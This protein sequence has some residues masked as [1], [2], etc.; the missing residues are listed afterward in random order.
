MLYG[1]E[2]VLNLRGAVAVVT[3]GS[4]GI[5]AAIAEE[6]GRAGAMV[7]VNYAGSVEPAE[8]LASTINEI[9]AGAEPYRR[10]DKPLRPHRHPGQQRRHEHRQAVGPDGSR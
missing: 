5:G 8:E 1:K 4:R 9:G 7:V 3:G 10:D 6:L 2:A